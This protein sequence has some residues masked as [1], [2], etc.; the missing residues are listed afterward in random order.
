MKLVFNTFLLLFTSVAFCQTNLLDTSSW[1]SGSGSVAGFN[2]YGS[3]SE[4]NRILA[5]SPFGTQEIIWVGSPDGSTNTATGGWSTTSVSI[6]PTKTYRLTVWIKKNNSFDGNVVFKTKISDSSSGNAALQLNGLAS[7]NPIFQANDVTTLGKWYLYVGFIHGYN[8]AGTTNIGG[9]YDPVNESLITA[10]TDYK[11][12]SNASTII[13]YAHLWS[14]GNSA[15]SL[16]LYA[17]TIFEVNGFEPSITEMLNPINN[18]QNCPNDIANL[19]NDIVFSDYRLGSGADTKTTV[20]NSNGSCGIRVVNNDVNQPWAKYQLLIDLAT[21]GL[22]PGDEL[23]I[24]AEAFVENGVGRLELVQDNTSNTALI[25]KTF[26]ADN[27]SPNLT[28]RITIPSGITTL[29][30]WLHCNYNLSNQGGSVIYSNLSVSKVSNTPSST[31]S[32]ESI[33]LE[34][35]TIAS[36]SGKVGIGTTNP[37]E[38]E[39]AV[40][41]KIRSKEVKV[42]TANWPDYVFTK[43]YKLP[44]L[45]EVEN[46]INEKGHLINIPSAIEAEANGVELGKMNRLLLEKLEELT[47]Y[48]IQL[49]KAN[50][51]Q[52]REIDA[53][54]LKFS[55]NE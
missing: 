43:N 16:E 51:M 4:N 48:I 13:H 42:E 47:L 31:P 1:T 8:Y 55:T 28:G 38:Y 20:A 6:D 37:G 18:T 41:G 21:N 53:I 2:K 27:S 36:Y 3:D 35:N 9:L 33:W 54:K 40:N 49:K 44:T 46:H 12:T 10:N 39:L 5:T 23:D 15:D 45:K 30:F 11:F 34:N 52:Q 26:S 7:S 19:S 29:N 24:S 25:S 22:V 17:P 14:S 32:G 50:N